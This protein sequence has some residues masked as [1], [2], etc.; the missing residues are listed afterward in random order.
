M[1]LTV[2]QL[3]SISGIGGSP[4]LIITGSGT[5]NQGAIKK[6]SGV[7]TVKIG[8]E[9]SFIDPLAFVNCDHLTS[10]EVDPLNNHYLSLDGVLYS[11]DGTT[12]L[13]YPSKRS[14]AH[15]IVP[16]SVTTISDGAFA[17]NP[18]LQ[19]ITIP[20]SVLTI[21]GTNF[22]NCLALTKVE[23]P[24][25]LLRVLNPF[26]A[27]NIINLILNGSG[28]ISQENFVNYT[29]LHSLVLGAG[30]NKIAPNTFKGLNNLVYLELSESNPFYTQIA[31]VIY[32]SDKTILVYYLPQNKVYSLSVSAMV[33]TIYDGAFVH[34]F[35]LGE[36]NV[37]VNNPVYMSSAGV[38]YN[39]E[40]TEILIIPSAS[41]ISNF[42]LLDTLTTIDP[43][44]FQ[45][46][47]YIHSF[48]ASENNLY[49]TT[50]N[51][52]LY[53]K[54]LTT[55]LAYPPGRANLTVVIPESVITIAPNAFGLNSNV[56]NLEVS[57]TTLNN[58]SESVG[59]FANLVLT[60]SGSGAL[61]NKEPSPALEKSPD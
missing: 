11:R 49:F 15:F 23:M 25:H 50:V 5:I 20:Q 30:I 8:P 37:D 17:N 56:K 45:N 57:L 58:I 28:E 31:G 24:V 59:T 6:I 39:K 44:A 10:I 32:N 29:R 14:E 42:V 35:N 13:V 2:A 9:V 7:T 38:V 16:S 40:C 18:Y 19:E 12:L 52:I 22:S 48:T 36:I 47:Q 3:N 26:L 21:S 55:L 33:E 34:A 41:L 60:I 53:N 27:K 54:D 43:S 46:Y 51:G 1:S 61:T 4:L